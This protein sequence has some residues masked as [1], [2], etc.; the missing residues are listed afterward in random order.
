MIHLISRPPYSSSLHYFWPALTSPI[1]I[2]I[3]KMPHACFRR[4]QKPRSTRHAVLEAGKD[5]QTNYPVELPWS[6]LREIDFGHLP[7]R[8]PREYMPFVVIYWSNFRKLIQIVFKFL[9]LYFSTSYLLIIPWSRKWHPTTVF[10][11]REFH[12][13]EDSDGLQS[14]GPQ[15]QTW[16]STHLLIE[17]LNWNLPW[18][19]SAPHGHSLTPHFWKMLS[20][21]F[22]PR[23]PH[24]RT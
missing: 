17:T 18:H 4:S 21:F 3:T 15:S 6:V 16:L 20:K 24:A 1:F 19:Q 14:M 9:D 22:S 10:L 11:P 8:T 5:K 7:S 2:L 23:D 12:G 13:L